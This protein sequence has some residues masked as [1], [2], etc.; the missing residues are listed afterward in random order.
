MKR[1][2]LSFSLSLFLAVLLA[3][4]SL[5]QQGDRAVRVQGRQAAGDTVNERRV[6]L[7]IGNSAYKAI[8]PLKNPVNDA[9]TIFSPH[10]APPP[11]PDRGLSPDR[12]ARPMRG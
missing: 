9:Q 6:V 11:L 7:V 8:S 3:A 10:T 2:V 5:A 1:P 4:P 12:N